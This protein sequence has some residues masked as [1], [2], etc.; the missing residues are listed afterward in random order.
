MR[1]WL[2]RAAG[3]E[4]RGERGGAGRSPTARTCGRCP[5]RCGVPVAESVL[6]PPGPIPNPVVTQNSAG[7][8]YGGDAMGG[9]AAAGAPHRRGSDPPHRRG[10]EQWQLVGLITQR[11]EVRIL[12]P[13]PKHFFLSFVAAPGVPRGLFRMLASDRKLPSRWCTLSDVRSS[14]SASQ[15]GVSTKGETWNSTTADRER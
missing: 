1:S 4:L 15:S 6:A 9:E 10:V 5:R 14:S 3:G 13:L 11:S 8:Y 2:R 7:E 12:P